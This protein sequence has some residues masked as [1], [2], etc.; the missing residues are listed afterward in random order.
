MTRRTLFSRLGLW[1]RGLRQLGLLCAGL[2]LAGWAGVGWSQV[3]A[4]DQAALLLN[5]ARTAFNDGNYPFA[6]QK[7]QEFSQKFGGHKDLNSARY[8]LG[9][10]VLHTRP[11]EWQKAIDALAPA[12]A[13]PDFADRPLALYYLGVAYRGFGLQL[14]EPAFLKPAEAKQHK[15]QAI[16]K[17]AVAIQT[18]TEAVKLLEEQV[19]NPKLADGPGPS[20]ELELALRARCDLAEMQIHLARIKEAQ[21]TTAIFVDDPIARHS[22]HA[23]LGRYLHGQ[24]AFLLNDY[25]GAVPALATNSPFAD[26]V[27]G[28]H[29]RYLLG[30]AHHLSGDR[31]EAA[32]QYLA[33][34]TGY[35]EQLNKAKAALANPMLAKDNPAEFT[36]L[37]T[38]TK[39]PPPEYVSRAAFYLGVLQGEREK[40]AEARDLF[41]AFEKKFPQSPLLPEAKLR[42]GMAMVRLK[43]NAEAAGLLTSLQDHPQLSDQARWWLGKAQA[44]A[45][46]PNSV[47]AKQAALGTAIGNLKIAAERAAAL[48]TDPEAKPRRSDILMELADYQ[49]QA[50]QAAEAANTYKEVLKEPPTPERAEEALQRLAT[51][52][53]LAGNLKESQE[54][55]V[56]FEAT[57]P[58]SP[59]LAAI[60]FRAA[61]NALAATELAAK[62]PDL[63]NREV[64]LAKLYTDAAAKYQQAVEQFPEAA[65]ANHARYGLAVCQYRLGKFAEAAKTLATIPATDRNGQLAPTSYL[66]GDCVLRNAPEDAEDA[67]SAGRVVQELTEA[68]KQIDTFIVGSPTHPMLPEALVKFAQCH[69]RLAALYSEPK[70]RNDS[71][72]LARQACEK[73]MAQF[74]ASPAMPLAVFERAKILVAQGDVGGSQNE[75]N[76]FTADPLKNAPVAPAALVRYSALLRSQ[77]KPADA[78][79]LLETCRQLHEAA[80]LKDI[81][82]KDWAPLIQYHQAL[83]T[84]ESGKL[85]EARALFEACAKAFPDKV[86]GADSVWRA[87]Q[88]RRM[89]A[90]TKLQAAQKVLANAAAPP[91]ELAQ[92]TQAVA[93]VVKALT[94]AAAY[95]DAQLPL[96]VKSHNQAAPHLQLL[97]EAAWIQ[98]ALAHQEIEAARKKLQD[99]AVKKLQDALAKQQPAPASPTVVHPPEIALTAIPLQPAEQKTRQMYQAIVAAAPDAPL[100]QIARFELSEVHA[101]REEHDPAIKLLQDAIDA[102]PPPELEEKVRLRLGACLLAKKDLKGAATQFESVAQSSA[103]HVAAEAR[104]RTAEVLM[105]EEKWEAAIK[106]LLPLQDDTKLNAFP[107]TSDRGLLRLAH[108]YA[109]AKQWEP[110]RKASE[111]LL[112]RFPQGP[113]AREAKYSLA[114]ALQNLGQHEPAI[115]AYREVTQQTVEEVA[116]RAQLQIGLCRL[117][118]KKL[119]EAVSELL[120]VP[121]FYDYPEHS[122]LALFEAASAF[123][124]MKQAD[125]A[126][127][128]LKKV[129][130]EHASTQWGDSAK[131]KLAE[132]K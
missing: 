84:L 12:S 27:F 131:K 116:A 54:T 96:V 30:R 80:L 128:L 91:P 61:E 62:K 78:A 95:L 18:L 121:Y 79:K 63:A 124:E 100:A 104:Y 40:F 37:E 17:F 88:C 3:S 9:L 21:E 103:P 10:A 15:D 129:S 58:K 99:E 41:D 74:A 6:L 73:V 22:H 111:T 8:G 81:D 51:A 102:E 125:Q 66:L 65:S 2:W 120:V 13:A 53:H 39:L 113:W 126:S 92:A 7:F 108:A 105:A 42:K 83:A 64:E 77:N 67:L 107:G 11:V 87:A 55:C 132:L 118:Q 72:N 130:T 44:G 5:S 101:L 110:S 43:Q 69:A 32:A 16:P 56:K 93:D 117:A 50:N 46:D 19:K 115:N 86:P 70:E 119:P 4:E 112:Q 82:R 89:E 25:A 26:P 47:A 114:W 52:L 85:P 29:A 127:R 45:A 35:D 23:N 24:A 49:Q 14:L 28:N 123:T 90:E 60:R 36:R 75:L 68:A 1:Q 76:R 38:L 20:P 97:Y 34:G 106:Q 59:L 31:E 71:L 48:K 57:Y 122:A 98:R 94:E 33:I 109:F